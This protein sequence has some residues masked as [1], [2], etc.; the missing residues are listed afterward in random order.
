MKRYVVAILVLVFMV[1]AA[2]V[3]AQS[4]IENPMR[5]VLATTGEIQ[6]IKNGTIRISGAGT[7][8]EIVLHVPDNAYLLNAQDGTTVSFGHLKKGDII[9]AY[10]GPQLA[11]SLPPQGTAIA[12]LVGDQKQG[13]AGMY[14]EVAKLEEMS[15]GSIRVLCTNGERLVTITPDVFGQIANIKEGSKLVVWY[16]IMTMSMPGQ[17]KATKVVLLSDKKSIQIHTGAGTIVIDG[18]EIALGEYDVI[19]TTPTTI[20][21]PLRVMAEALGY[22]V[23][24][25][26]DKGTVELQSSVGTIATMTIGSKE[27]G[28]LK[29]AVPLDDAPEIVNGKTLVPV[30]FFTQVLNIK[31]AVSNSH[32]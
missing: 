29:M 19:Q 9:T 23:S 22:T 25:D 20:M 28:K 17:A 24:W 31:V 4:I 18:Q 7:Y 12:L 6:E 11:K 27:Y 13:G 32:I 26:G 2:N 1:G 10:Y 21:L 15:N 3:F 30:E 8:S 5:N 14:M 16:D